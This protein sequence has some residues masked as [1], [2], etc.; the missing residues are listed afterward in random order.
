M[1]HTPIGTAVEIE[2]TTEPAVSV[3]DHGPGVA[4][5]LRERVTQRF[6]RARRANGNGSGLGLAIVKRIAEAH[7]GRIEVDDA[8]G[9]GA[10]FILRL[11]PNELVWN[12]IESGSAAS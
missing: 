8:P 6:W 1:Q 5:E 4:I 9:G 3:N 11:P 10:R 7:G 2:V 12:N